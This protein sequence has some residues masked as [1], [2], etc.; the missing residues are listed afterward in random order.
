MKKLS[1]VRVFFDLEGKKGRKEK[2]GKEG[3]LIETYQLWCKNVSTYTLSASNSSYKFVFVYRHHIR[4]PKNVP[5][6]INIPLRFNLFPFPKQWGGM[7]VC[8]CACVPC[9][10]E[11]NTTVFQRYSS[12]FSSKP[13]T[14]KKKKGQWAENSLFFPYPFLPSFFASE[15]IWSVFLIIKVSET[16]VCKYV[17]WSSVEKES[18][19]KA[20]KFPSL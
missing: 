4:S 16:L 7:L 13:L 12:I 17:I 5:Y 11:W 3:T 9:T 18:W 15:T 20:E 14:E 2:E 19:K 6:P 10:K 1:N 8:V